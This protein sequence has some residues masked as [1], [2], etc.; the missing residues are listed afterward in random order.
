MKT[1]TAHRAWDEAWRSE[2]GRAD[3][4]VPDQD[5][6]TG[7]KISLEQGGR[8]ALDLGCGVGRHA[9]ALATAGFDVSAIDASDT[10]IEHLKGRG[11][12]GGPRHRYA[13]RLDDG[14][15]L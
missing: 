12:Q 1:A 10:G 7:A 11:R 9:L 14:T 6:I 8:R 4:L 5:V 15:P 13:G 2:D 3:W